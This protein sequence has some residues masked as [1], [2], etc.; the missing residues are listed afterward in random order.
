MKK[1]HLI[2]RI[3][4]LTAACL[5][6]AAL[7]GTFP[8]SA[9]QSADALYICINEVCTQN[10]HCYSDSL[11]KASDWIEL[12]NGGNAAADLS[13]FGLS[14]DASQPM[15]YVFPS[16]TAIAPGAYLLIAAAKKGT[17][18]TELNT[19]FALSKSGETLLLSLPDGTALQ[20]LE[21]PALAEDTTF[22]RTSDGRYAVM[23]PTP[24]SA[25]HSAPAEP[26]FS[27]E[28]GFYSAGQVSELTIT[29]AD[30]IY[31]TLDGSDPTTSETAVL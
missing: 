1:R 9:E 7:P 10:K 30:S 5:T 13:G 12:Y 18:E 29:A 21:I 26:V 15:K 11:G 17:Y 25:N 3:C 23:T 19:G 6:A 27:L 20:T 4:S 22:G 14:D 31:Y 28:S 24:A 16:G 2:N 8:V